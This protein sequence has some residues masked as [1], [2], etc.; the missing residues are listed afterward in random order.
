MVSDPFIFCAYLW[1]F[2]VPICG[3]SPVGCVLPVVVVLFIICCLCLSAPF[4]LLLFAIIQLCEGVSIEY[5][6]VIVDLFT[7]STS[8]GTLSFRGCLYE[9]SGCTFHI[10]IS[11]EWLVE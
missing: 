9:E 4:I 5:L 10:L 6:T 11:A 8:K 7:A 1:R 2:V 3:Q